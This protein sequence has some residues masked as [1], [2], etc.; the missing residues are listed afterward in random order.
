[1]R[2]RERLLL[3][4]DS[5]RSKN[6][7]Y[8]ARSWAVFLNTD[9]STLSQILRGSRRVPVSCLRA[10]AKK[11]KI[12]AEE[13]AAY[14][15]AEHVPD[16]QTAQRQHQL[17]Q[18]TAEAMAL[19]AEPV[20]WRILQLCSNPEFRPDCRW[21]AER[22]AASVDEVNL[23]VSRLLRLRLIQVSHAVWKDTT[24]PRCLTA[25]E[26]RKVALARVRKESK[27]WQIQ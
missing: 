21:I 4:F 27:E 15:A 23:A 1:M 25:G 5:R 8:S 14:I 26:F 12:G 17:R 24:G 3:E 13:T 18:W 11:L 16:T 6:P 2:F 7:R 10:W 22:I 19:T 20:H 9:H